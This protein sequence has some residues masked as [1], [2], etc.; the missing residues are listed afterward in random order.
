MFLIILIR[1]VE[2]KF[3]FFL[4]LTLYF[5]SVSVSANYSK[6]FISTKCALSYYQTNINGQCE[7]L[8]K[9]GNNLQVCSVLRG[10][11]GSMYS[12]KYVKNT[13]KD[14]ITK[15]APIVKTN[16]SNPKYYNYYL[17]AKPKVIQH[18]YSVKNVSEEEFVSDWFKSCMNDKFSSFFSK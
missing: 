15:Y 10:F 12:R 14:Q 2:I 16:P 1:K 17:L 6:D 4:F 13:T 8:A 7:N 11:S 3:R 18:L 9:E 5:L